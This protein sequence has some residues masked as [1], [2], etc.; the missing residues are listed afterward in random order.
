MNI[1][2]VTNLVA[3]KNKKEHPAIIEENK[4]QKATGMC[5]I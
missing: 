1:D 5:V 2:H 4:P 3:Q